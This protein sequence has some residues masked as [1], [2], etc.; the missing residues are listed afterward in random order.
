MKLPVTIVKDISEAT[1]PGSIEPRH[2]DGVLQGYAIRCPG[3]NNES[4]LPV[5]GKSG[6]VSIS[7]DPITINPSVFHTKEAG[8]CGWHGYLKNGVWEG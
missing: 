1:E 4:W 3:C 6:W 2:I 5:R 8:G 7:E